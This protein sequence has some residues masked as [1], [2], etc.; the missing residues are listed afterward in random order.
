[1][2]REGPEGLQRV[3]LVP[4]ACFR[5]YCAVLCYPCKPETATALLRKARCSTVRACGCSSCDA[6]ND[7]YPC[8]RCLLLVT[9]SIN[10]QSKYCVP[11]R[12]EALVEP[13]STL[14]TASI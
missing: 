10:S 7:N 8:V 14:S 9:V 6:Y 3:A 1:M 13:P 11:S 4:H 12:G 2:K 5:V